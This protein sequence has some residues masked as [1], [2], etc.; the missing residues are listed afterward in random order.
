MLRVGEF[1]TEVETPGG[2]WYQVL[3]VS[4]SSV[5]VAG[6][7]HD[8]SYDLPVEIPLRSSDVV[9]RRYAE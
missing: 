1:I 3:E 9:L 7:T 5:V 6:G 8:D 2:P 4:T